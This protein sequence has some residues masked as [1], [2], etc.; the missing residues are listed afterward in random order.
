MN[1]QNVR[2]LRSKLQE[3]YSSIEASNYDGIILTETWLHSAINDAEVVP[4]VFV[5][6]RRDRSEDPYS[7]KRGSGISIAVRSC[8]VSQHIAVKSDIEELWMSVKFG[9]TVCIFCAVYIPLRSGVDVYDNHAFSIEK[10][11]DRY[12]DASFYVAGDYN[13]PDITWDMN[14]INIIEPKKFTLKLFICRDISL[15]KYVT[16]QQCSKFQ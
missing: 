16:V 14:D 9:K 2:G 6:Y 1:Y 7:L 15:S 4:S 10:I 11:C 12:P 3:I 13:T 8:F 5:L